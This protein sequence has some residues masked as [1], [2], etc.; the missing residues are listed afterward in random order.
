MSHSKR[1]KLIILEY[2]RK[3]LDYWPPKVRERTAEVHNNSFEESLI[4]K[5]IIQTVNRIRS[6]CRAPYEK[7]ERNTHFVFWQLEGLLI[8]WREKWMICGSSEEQKCNLN[9]V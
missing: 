6:S 9:L 7:W 1:D 2:I 4:N 8:I 5:F 3:E